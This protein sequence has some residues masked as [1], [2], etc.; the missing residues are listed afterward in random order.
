AVTGCLAISR[1]PQVLLAFNPFYGVSL[2][3]H[4]PGFA[5]AIVGAV[6]LAVTGGEALYADMGHFGRAPVRIA[7]FLIVWPAL[8]VNYFGQGALRSEEHTSELQSRQ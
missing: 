8:I 1:A 3:A 4:R 2:L 6:F 7:W 5:L